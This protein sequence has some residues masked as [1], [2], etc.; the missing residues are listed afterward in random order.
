M[1]NVRK[2]AHVLLNG[3]E[4]HLTNPSLIS[5]VF[6]E[7]ADDKFTLY[8]TITFSFSSPSILF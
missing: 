1:K 6:F 2:H 8:C 7:G 5:C 4:L 3:V